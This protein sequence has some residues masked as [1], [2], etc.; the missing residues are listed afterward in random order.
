[1]Q[2]Y[3]DTYIC[4]HKVTLKKNTLKNNGYKQFM[5]SPLAK[6]KANVST[7]SQITIPKM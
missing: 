1:M 4:L 5:H 2:R 6:A 3:M 7:M